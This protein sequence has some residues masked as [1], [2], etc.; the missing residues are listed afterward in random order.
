METRKALKHASESARH[1][2]AAAAAAFCKNF[3]FFMK[4]LLCN[5][6]NLL[7][8]LDDDGDNAGDAGLVLMVLPRDLTRIKDLMEQFKEDRNMLIGVGGTN[9]NRLF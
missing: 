5:Y 4:L 9:G 3:T 1:V 7:P 6:S 2:A 8:A